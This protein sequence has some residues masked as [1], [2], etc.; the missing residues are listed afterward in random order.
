MTPQAINSLSNIIGYI[1]VIIIL[2]A[3][4][5]SQTNKINHNRYTYSVSN[6]AGALCLLIS[7]YFQP[8]LPSITIEIAWLTIS[9]IGIIKTYQ[10]RKKA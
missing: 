10:K 8:N 4:Y 7:L 3:Y 9:A 5:C 6:L 2:I 1:G